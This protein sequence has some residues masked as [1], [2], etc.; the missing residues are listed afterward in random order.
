MKKILLAMAIAGLASADLFAQTG[1][2]VNIGGFQNTLYGVLD[3]GVEF[4]N[5][6][7]GVGTK[8]RIQSGQGRASRLG[9]DGK[10][11]LNPDLSLIYRLEAGFTLDNANAFSVPTNTTNTSFSDNGGSGASPQTFFTRDAYVGF[12]GKFGR[13]ILGRTSSHMMVEGITN[14]I[15][16]AITAAT[17][18]NQL[19]YVPGFSIRFNN[20]A[21]YTSPDLKGFRASL[22]LSSG[23]EGNTSTAVANNGKVISLAGTYNQGPLHLTAV[24]QRART[25]LFSPPTSGAIGLTLPNVTDVGGTAACQQAA[26]AN[27]ASQA[28]GRPGTYNA[29]TCAF[30]GPT[31]S[32]SGAINQNVAARSWML[33]GKYNFGSFTVS[34][35]VDSGTTD[36]LGSLGTVYKGGG[37]H[38]GVLVPFADKHEVALAYLVGQADTILGNSV[39]DG[40]AKTIGLRYRYSIDKATTLYAAFAREQ[41]GRGAMAPVFSNQTLT[42][43]TSAPAS[44]GAS[45]LNTLPGSSPSVLQLGGYFSF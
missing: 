25:G 23:S 43:T 27:A 36:G 16:G 13:I 37:W 17:G 8:T 29:A 34:G 33:G 14:D 20:L 44:S 7:I 40:K 26:Q 4:G 10:K 31:L 28:I 38:L 24:A 30:T 9:F 39:A 45:A 32:N 19:I 15:M 5:A 35:M 12:D 3:G 2:T 18:A 22:G 42:L 6:D 11:E 1:P 41:I 21:Q